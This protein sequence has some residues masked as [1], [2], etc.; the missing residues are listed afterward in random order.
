MLLK[1]SAKTSALHVAFG[2]TKHFREFFN[3][4]VN[5]PYQLKDTMT[6]TVNMLICIQL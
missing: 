1:K 5:V 4:T 2:A 3:N 6:H